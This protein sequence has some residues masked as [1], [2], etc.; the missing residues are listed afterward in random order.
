MTM[1]SNLWHPKLFF[2]A[3]LADLSRR[4]HQQ[5]QRFFSPLSAGPLHAQVPEHFPKGLRELPLV[6]MKDKND[7]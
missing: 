5:S 3:G 4:K 7:E 2:L 1:M 6:S